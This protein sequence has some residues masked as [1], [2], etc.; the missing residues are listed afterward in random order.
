MEQVEPSEWIP[1]IVEHCASV[2]LK[3]H[4]SIRMNPVAGMHGVVKF[5]GT[6]L[7]CFTY[8]VFDQ[9]IM[10]F[11]RVKA[12]LSLPDSIYFEHEVIPTGE[13]LPEVLPPLKQ[14]YQDPFFELMMRLYGYFP[15]PMPEKDA[16]EVITI[17]GETV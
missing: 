6:S 16:S 1:R 5:T 13:G 4:E 12:C 9:A 7:P 3:A 10:E 14:E 2:E 8:T 15:F 11:I 17:V